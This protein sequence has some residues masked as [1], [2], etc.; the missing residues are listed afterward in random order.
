MCK[1]TLT[2][3]RLSLQEG[4]RGSIAHRKHSCYQLAAPG[5]IPIRDGGSFFDW[6]DSIEGR[7]RGPMAWLVSGKG[8]GLARGLP[9]YLVFS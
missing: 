8:L 9:A 6:Q 5:L 2:Y 7:G 3:Q 4:G 1:S